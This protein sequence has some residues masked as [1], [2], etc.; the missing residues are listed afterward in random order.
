MTAKLLFLSGT[1]GRK[2]KRNTPTNSNTNY[3]RKMKL[4]PMNV[5]Y[6][7]LQ[8]DALKF[9]LRMSLHGGSLPSINFFLNVNLQIF[10]RNC[11]NLFNC[12]ET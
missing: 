5:E 3:R 2:K 11:R 4:V 1:V 9:F 7:L 10:Q 6:F 8:F 12:L